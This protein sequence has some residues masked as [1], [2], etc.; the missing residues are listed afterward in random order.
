[1][2]N[3]K[4]KILPKCQPRTQ[5]LRGAIVGSATF[6]LASA[7]A[8]ANDVACIGDPHWDTFIKSTLNDSPPS[9]SGVVWALGVHDDILYV[10]RAVNPPVTKWNGNTWQDLAPLSPFLP[11]AIGS[12]NGDLIVGGDFGEERIFRWDGASWQSLG[13]GVSSSVVSMTKWDGNLV[14]GGTFLSAG[15]QTVNRIARWDGE[16]WHPFIDSDTGVV[17]MNGTVWALTVWNG[18]LYAAGQFGSAGGKPISAIARWDGRES[19]WEPLGGGFANAILALAIHDGDLVA[20]GFFTQTAD[21]WCDEICCGFGDCCHDKVEA[22]DGCL[23]VGT[24]FGGSCVGNCGSAAVGETVFANRVAR[25]DGLSW[26][27]LGEGVDDVV[28]TLA[29]YGDDLYAG[30]WFSSAGSTD[31]NL[32]AR[33]DGN[34]WHDIELSSFAGGTLHVRDLTEFRDGLVTGG[35]FFHSTPNSS[36]QNLIEYRQC[37]ADSDGDGIRDDWEVNG[38]PY[39]AVDGTEMRYPLPKADPMRKNLWVEVDSMPGF[40]LSDEAIN[41][42]PSIS[43]VKGGTA[44]ETT[45]NCGLQF[46][47]DNA[48]VDNPDGST[49]IILHIHRDETTPL[50]H[51]PELPLE[52]VLPSDSCWPADFDELRANHFGT[53]EERED[54]S[55]EALLEAK[56][57][58]FRYA[59]IVDRPEPVVVVDGVPDYRCLG[60]APMPGDDLVLYFGVKTFNPAEQAGLFM[61]EFGHSLGLNHGGGDDVNGKPNHPS[62]MNY[63]LT[64]PYGWNDDFWRLDYSRVGNEELVD[65]QEWCLH[66]PDG[67]GA[68][69]GFYKD[70]WMPF[71]ADGVVDWHCDAEIPKDPDDLIRMIRYVLLNGQPADWSGKDTMWPDCEFSFCVEQDLNYVKGP[72]QNPDVELPTKDS[73]NETLYAHN[74]W[75][76]VAN[77]LATQAVQGSAAPL[78]V[79]PHND[80]TPAAFDW[81]NENFPTPPEPKHPKIPEPPCDQ[82]SDL[83]GGAGGFVRSLAVYNGELIAGGSFTTAGGETVNNIARWDGL[84]W[85]PLESGGQ[86]GVNG[87]VR[88]MIVHQGELIV[89]GQFTTA[90]GQTVNRI[91]RW[92]GSSWEPFVVDDW[93]GMEGPVLAL[94]V[95]DDDLVVAG[96]FWFVGGFEDENLFKYI[97]RWDG[98]SWHPFGE[99]GSYGTQWEINAL[100][101][102]EGDLVA[103][104]FF[105]FAGGV[106]ANK[107]ARWDGSTWHPFISSG[108]VGVTFFEVFSLGTYD[109][110]LIA[111][112]DLDFLTDGGPVL[113]GI[114][115]WDGEAW[116]PLNSG[117]DGKVFAVTEYN[118]DLI[119][120][121][122]FLTA[123]GQSANRI[124]RWDGSDWYPFIVDVDVGT[125]GGIEALATQDDVLIAGGFFSLAGG[126]TVENVAR[127][128]DCTPKVQPCPADLTGSG[129]VTVFDLL[130]LLGQW[131]PCPARPAPC[132][133]D[134]DGNGNVNVFDLLDLL[135]QW[136][137]CP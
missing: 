29:V 1:M 75:A 127:W 122:Y 106:P 3:A 102:Y 60:V 117:V 58:A 87:A 49:G 132:P 40:E 13:G 84:S 41:G 37:L 18:D 57:K 61:H 55:G 20:G 99:K 126:A 63:V 45:G 70:F 44:S 113:D 33:W 104:G 134:L 71:G 76:F 54:P 115:R 31:A 7:V 4:T 120:G 68:S 42:D 131:G 116:H 5:C 96:N 48:P 16:T 136:G 72:L 8:S 125:S 59:I 73:P 67:L 23:P 21:C 83:A 47:F 97:A 17:G 32:I 90:G 85:K 123:G 81:V 79:L 88:S 124:A 66:E 119:A 100:T 12:Y 95:Y 78:S 52:G 91:A 105:S 86:I 110:D 114:A 77:N 35:V 28:E 98:S 137:A 65:L 15:G 69:T 46:A 39:T 130:E 24:T 74:D 112:A 92:D 103:G 128:R 22:C 107:I 101:I 30:G 43:C 38:I 10:G 25:W 56:A 14:V 135:G 133:A 34:T 93:I 111:G 94:A 64:F 2:Q 6:A 11:R 108:K 36:A 89:G 50:P 62:I 9:G 51:V 118:G 82:W 80:L 27:P 129:G 121:G 53:K 109:S 26:H 19:R